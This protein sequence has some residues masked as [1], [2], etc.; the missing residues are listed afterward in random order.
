M[1]TERAKAASVIVSAVVDVS[2]VLV[3]AVVGRASHNEGVL[4]LFGTAWPFLGGLAVGWL[5]L[6]AW[7]HPSRVVWTGFGIWIAT[8]AGGILLRLVSGQTAQL[9]FIL[10]ATA[11]LGVLLVGWR[12][13]STLI[14]RTSAS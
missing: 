8:V 3:F 6:R 2:L 13:L 10:V 9:P 7:R 14:T 4:G 5:G 12:A 1:G 11:A